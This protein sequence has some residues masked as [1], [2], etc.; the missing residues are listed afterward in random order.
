MQITKDELT[1]LS[2]G[3]R[4]LYYVLLFVLTTSFFPYGAVEE[5][6]NGIVNGSLQFISGLINQS[7]G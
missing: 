1:E 3:R 5:D 4:V 6:F 2:D 7:K